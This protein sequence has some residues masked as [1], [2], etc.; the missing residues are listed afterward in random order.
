MAQNWDTT[1]DVVVIGYGGAG[2][3]A[4]LAARE[5]GAD[6]LALDR[7]LGG[8]AT[9][10]SGGI[11]YAGGGTRIQRA[12]GIE[13]DVENMFSYLRLEVGD[14]VSEATL[15]RFCEQSPAMI[16]WLM[17]HG[18]PFDPS[19]CPFKTSYPTDDYYLYFSGSENS[20]GFRDAA[21]PRQR[22]HRAHGPG[23][24]GKKLYGPL[25]ASAAAHGVRLRTGTR[26]TG[27]VVEDG[28]VVGVEAVTIEGAPAAVR[29]RFALLTRI[30]AK[31][32]VYHQG[33]RATMQRLLAR[34]ERRHGRPIRVH[35]RAGV[36][37]STGGF[38]ANGAMVRAHAPGYPWDQGLPLG[39]AGDDGSGIELGRSV[40][41]VTDR[42]DSLSNWRFIAP[43]SAY[44]GALAVDAHGR[45]MVDES[46]YGAALGAA[47]ADA[48][49]H[50]AWLLVDADLATAARAQIGDQTV[51]FQRLQLERLLRIGSVSAPTVEEA[52]RRAGIDPAG[53]RRTVDA[54]NEAIAHGRP[55][56]FGKPDDLRRPA[57]AAPFTLLDISFTDRMSYPMPML[58]LGGLVVDE[59]TGAVRTT[60][61]GTVDGLY[62]AGR[63]AVGVCSNSYV[64]GLSLA[65]CIFSG[66]RAGAA[67]VTNGRTHED[68]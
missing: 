52:A 45:R 27:L 62:A 13:D 67:A 11:V 56:P 51:W 58:T 14:A 1:A 54:H 8:G 28:R 20:G 39:T 37:L 61:G 9:N 6:V 19:L 15:R 46:R 29:R 66:R 32:G 3:A 17:T 36:V 47:I 16:D 5:T 30:S 59:E 55:D 10:L 7:Y 65:D 33:L 40:G 38:I 34:I 12:A 64:S 43:P 31:P 2:V 68:V 35:A 24:S 63:T 53:L 48:P 4:A 41:A 44:L 50:R 49:G 25:A 21:V 26:V 18:V 57:A 23:V 42:M 22:G 60:A